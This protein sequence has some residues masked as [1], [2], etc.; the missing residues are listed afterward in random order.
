MHPRERVL[1]LAAL[2]KQR[3]QRIPIDLLAQADL[4]GLDISEFDEPT[5][6]HE[7]EEGDI[8]NVEAEE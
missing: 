5:I 1:N 3:G 8:L 2:Y 6:S 4:L 7:T